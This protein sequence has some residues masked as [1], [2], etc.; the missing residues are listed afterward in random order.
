MSDY[1]NVGAVCF[2]CALNAGFTPKKTCGVWVGECDI[3]KR[4]KP[5]T[6]FR[7]DWMIAEKRGKKKGEDDG[8]K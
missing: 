3:C 8:E 4:K 6:D 7:H 2:D 5:C 1:S